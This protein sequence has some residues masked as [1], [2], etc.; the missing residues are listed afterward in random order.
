MAHVVKM[1]RVIHELCEICVSFM[2]FFKIDRAL[3]TSQ[4]GERKQGM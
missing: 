4:E 3:V 2:Y 1:V